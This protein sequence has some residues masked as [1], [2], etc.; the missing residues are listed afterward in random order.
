VSTTVIDNGTGLAWTDSEIPGAS[1]HDTASI[2]GQQGGIAAGGTV[3]YSL[4]SNSGCTGTATA[5]QQVTVNGDGTVPNSSGT[6]P[7]AA[8]SY[9]FQAVYSGDSNYGGSTSSCESFT[10]V[11]AATTVDTTV[12]DDGTGLPWNGTATTGASAH[13]SATVTGQQTGFPAGGTVIYSFFNNGSCSGTATTT[14]TVTL[15]AAGAV[16]DSNTTGAL[17]GGSHAFQASYSGDGN[18]DPSTGSCEPFTVSAA[19]VT[20]ATTVID[21]ATSA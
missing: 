4:F 12:I 14:Q 11:A 5:S 2:G 13:D 18:Y 9:A 10:V 21:D 17:A 6:G 1:G 8:G 7:L 19:P 3:T 16:P 20:V 15:D